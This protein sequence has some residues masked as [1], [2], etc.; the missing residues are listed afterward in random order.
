MSDFVDH[1]KVCAKFVV[2]AQA[3]SNVHYGGR[4][5]IYAWLLQLYMYYVRFLNQL[6]VVFTFK[7]TQKKKK[8]T[9][10]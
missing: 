7:G 5:V 3:Q 10:A 1:E 6:C 8:N 4:V 9:V 2:T